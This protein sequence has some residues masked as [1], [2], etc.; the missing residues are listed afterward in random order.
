[1]IVVQLCTKEWR[2]WIL[3]NAPLWLA[4]IHP[5]TCP[6]SAPIALHSDV[7]FFDFRPGRSKID[8]PHVVTVYRDKS[9]P[10][11]Y[12]SILPSNLPMPHRSIVEQWHYFPSPRSYCDSTP[13]RRDDS[14]PG[15]VSDDAPAIRIS[16]HHPWRIVIWHRLGR[17]SWIPRGRWTIATDRD[18][19]NRRAATNSRPDT[20]WYTVDNTAY[21]SVPRV[22]WNLDVLRRPRHLSH[23]DR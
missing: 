1:M 14:D 8:S 23:L 6:N 22:M 12:P 7:V 10:A 3:G 16:I 17:G 4:K 19:R 2:T 11:K 15:W 21:P 20:R 9:V 13:R 5:S 18:G